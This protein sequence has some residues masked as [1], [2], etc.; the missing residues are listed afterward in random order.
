MAKK[1]R[2]TDTPEKQHSRFVEAAKQAE[3]DEG[4][5]AMDNAFKRISPVKPTTPKATAKA[6]N[7][8]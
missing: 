8:Q 3:A 7:G 1:K 6:R 4:P 2:S 5:D